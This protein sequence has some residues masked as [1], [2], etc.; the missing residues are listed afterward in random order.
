MLLAFYFFYVLSRIIT[1]KLHWRRTLVQNIFTEL[2][3]PYSCLCNYISKVENL[4]LKIVFLYK[5]KIMGQ[6]ITIELKNAKASKLLK[7]LEDLKIIKIVSD[8]LLGLTGKKRIQGRNFLNALKQAKLAE[9][10]KIK[11]KTL[12][13]LIDEL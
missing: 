10:G 4:V 7:D 2:C 12:D 6:K 11:L 3:S 1:I 5:Q 8:P 13:Q 9:Q